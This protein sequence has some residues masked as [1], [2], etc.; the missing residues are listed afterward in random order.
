MRALSNNVRFGGKPDMAFVCETSA[1]DPK[2]TKPLANAQLALSGGLRETGVVISRSQAAKPPRIMRTAI[3]KISGR[4][5]PTIPTAILI[6]SGSWMRMAWQK[7]SISFSMSFPARPALKGEHVYN[8][9]A[10]RQEA[11][12]ALPRHGGS[13]S[14]RTCGRHTTL[15]HFRRSGTMGK[16]TKRLG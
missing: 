16:P 5:P 6:E 2:R 10:S 4:P 9:Y 11:A 13:M 8:L 12:A 3:M 1:N 15:R 14:S 7:M